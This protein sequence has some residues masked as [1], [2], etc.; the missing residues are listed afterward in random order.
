MIPIRDENPT[1][2]TA[3]MTIALLVANVL[4]S[5]WQWILPAQA[6]QAL[7]FEAGFIPAR[8]SNLLV[9]DGLPPTLTLLSSQFLHGGPLHLAGNMLFL[10]IFGNN[11]EEQMGALRFLVFYLLC[12]VI[13]G[14]VHFASGP[15]SAVPAVGASGAI[16]GVLGAYA[17]LFPTARVHTL[18]ILVFYVTVVPIPALLWVA[19]WFLYQ[20]VGGLAN[21]GVGGGVAWFAHI[22]GLIGGLLLFAL[23]RKRRARRSAGIFGTG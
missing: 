5:L 15:S 21:T 6:G 12:G 2:T 14:L 10:W 16:S 4:V 3:W 20:I 18:V 11:V 7:V 1:R 17:V 13:A 8:L 9:A 23:F 22:G 19:I